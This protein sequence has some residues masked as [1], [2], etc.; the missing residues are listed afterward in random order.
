MVALLALL[1]GATLG[2][3]FKVLALV[4]AIVLEDV[5]VLVVGSA[6]AKSLVWLV[7]AVVIA[8]VAIQ[9]GYLGTAVVSSLVRAARRGR[10]K[11]KGEDRFQDAATPTPQHPPGRAQWIAPV[12]GRRLFVR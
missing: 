1:A 7:C 9:F 10:D 3:R 5:A 2:L 12:R 11:G 4:P 6:Q 8:T